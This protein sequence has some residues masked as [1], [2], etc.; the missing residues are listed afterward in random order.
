MK[1]N[2]EL[3]GEQQR[4][5][6]RTR[7]PGFFVRL[8]DTGKTYAIKD[9]SATGFAILDESK[10]FTEGETHRVD[11]FLKQKPFL[12]DLKGRVMRVVPNGIIGWNFED[13]DRRQEM[14]L[15]KLVLE[16]Q[17]RLIKMKKQKSEER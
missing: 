7:V 5:A 4:K 11:L 15:D 1:L 12:E 17:K 2:L 16:V 14:R 10:S 6:F 9:L 3:D 8:R 13:M